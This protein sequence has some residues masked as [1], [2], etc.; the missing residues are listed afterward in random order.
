MQDHSQFIRSIY[1]GN[2]KLLPNGVYTPGFK[3]SEVET[4]I[5]EIFNSKEGADSYAQRYKQHD[6]FRHHI[7]RA[8]SVLGDDPKENSI[9][10]DIG[11]G[12]GNTVFPS[13][14]I[15]PE[16]RIIATD[17]SIHLLD[18]LV[19]S[20]SSGKIHA[21]Q[22]NAEDL[23]FRPE[24]FDYVIGGA[25]LHHLFRPNQTI[26]QAIQLLKPGG[27]SVFFE[28]CQNGQY[29]VKS[30]Y[31]RVLSD[32]RSKKL[33]P[34]IVKLLK[35]QINFIDLRLRH[36][37][38]KSPEIFENLEDKWLFP[39]NYLKDIAA[40]AGADEIMVIPL[41]SSERL[42]ESKMR[43]NFRLLNA[44]VPEWVWQV[45]KDYDASMTDEFKLDNPAGVTVIC[46]KTGENSMVSESK[47]TT[48]A[49]FNK[50]SQ[51]GRVD[52]GKTQ[53]IDHLV[54]VYQY[55]KVGSTAITASL[56]KWKNIESV[57]THFLGEKHLIESLKAT[58]NPQLP[59][60][61]F[62]HRYG[63]LI[64]N[65]KTTRTINSYKAGLT[66]DPKLSIITLTR[67]PMSWFRSCI[68][69]DIEGYLPFFRRLALH[70]GPAD[71]SDHQAIVGGLH[72]FFQ[73]AIIILESMGDIDTFFKKNSNFSKVA[74]THDLEWIN[75][76]I[77]TF[78][79][80]MMRPNT[81]FQE[82]FSHYLDV[83]ITDFQQCSPDWFKFD[84]KWA[85]L[86]LIKYERLQE[87][88][89]EV[90]RDIELPAGITLSP[91]NISESKKF[92]A[93]VAEGFDCDE[94]RF[95]TH[96]IKTTELQRFLGY[97]AS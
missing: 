64:Q 77:K 44:K 68:L 83:K 13:L 29:L 39:K 21:V 37:P 63:Q 79:A 92:S 69:Q 53:K 70:Q 76:N 72:Y 19:R 25:I 2:L 9:I 16:S 12:S 45:A 95:L 73:K 5:H 74:K 6:Y 82:H 1:N 85:K 33:D 71:A 58:I 75:H 35:R 48:G 28:P 55:G 67:D 3:T 51:A 59:P 52:T 26:T 31:E 50:I 88:F 91:E 34:Q 54:A 96:A 17:L 7:K 47:S 84:S 42:V 61:F 80:M 20:D 40:A 90:A 23:R 38:D 78:F 27:V 46:R 49:S 22:Q 65:I 32:T 89:P 60:Y 4:Y 56:N 11:S 81:W 62:Q 94:A 93:A 8:L 18:A 87:A 24:S 10:L 97:A 57:Q 43:S 14:E 15:F 66:S 36:R 41:D 30:G 86:Y